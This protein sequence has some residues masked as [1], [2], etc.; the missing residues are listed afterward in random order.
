MYVKILE[1]KSNKLVDAQII[2]G[3][4]RML[5]GIQEGWRF[6][7]FKRSKS[8]DHSNT[9]ALVVEQNKEIVEGCLIYRMKKA[10]EPY[11]AYVE[12]APHN[13]GIHK[14]HDRV[15]GC[16][17]AFACRLSFLMGKDHFMGWLAFDVLEES[18][19]DEVRL[20]NL[21]SKKYYAQRFGQTTT[22]IIS[23]ENGEKLIEEYLETN[24]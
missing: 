21:Y 1:V 6:N 14:I 20:M 9:Y 13:K 7:F 15:A 24:S 12:V 18:K 5:P 3:K 2:E 19:E 4:E 10:I 8:K 22:M 23:P 17:I 16:L 11:I